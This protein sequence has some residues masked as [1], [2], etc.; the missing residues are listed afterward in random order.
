[1]FALFGPGKKY[2]YYRIETCEELV[3]LFKDSEFMDKRD[4]TQL[5][6]LVLHYKDA[7]LPVV[8]ATKAVEE[9]NKSKT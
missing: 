5:V 3:N 9:F 2:R 6:E 1:M 7:P 8:L 4:R